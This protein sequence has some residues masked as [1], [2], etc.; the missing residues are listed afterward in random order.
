MP[1]TRYA[2]VLGLGFGDC[3][4]GLFVDALTRRWRAHSV[5][6][7]NGGA[8]AGH[9]VVT[10]PSGSLPSHHHTFSQFAAGTFNLGVRSILASPFW[11]HPGA[12]LVE[13]QRLAAI[14]QEDALSRLMIDGECPLVSPFHQAAG[15]LRELSRG[16]QAH[17]SCGV[18][19]GETVA[20]NQ[21]APGLS[22]HYRMLVLQTTAARTSLLDLLQTIR[23]ELLQ[24]CQALPFEGS[25]ASGN[26]QAANEWAV[27]NNEGLARQWINQ[28][29]QLHRACPASSA[30]E[31]SEQLRRPGAAI[32]EGAQGILLDECHGF[33]PHTTWSST[34]TA[35]AERV[36]KCYGLTSP[37]AHLGVLRS[38]LT[39]HGPGPLPTQCAELDA[40]SEPHNSSTGWQ[41]YFRRGHPD[42]VLQRYALDCVGPLHGLLLSHLDVFDRGMVLKWCEGYR[43]PHSEL[44]PRLASVGKAT[45]DEAL[46]QRLHPNHTQD[47]DHQSALT[48]LLNV[49]RPQYSVQP[50]RHADELIER[51]RSLSGLAVLARS[52]GPRAGDI[53]FEPGIDV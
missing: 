1:V 8:Q 33:H 31:I 23:K 41:G 42:A 29:T 34:G 38:Y 49:A 24:R 10:T 28:L 48:R 39:R 40:L 16:T 52:F 18:G 6:R 11:I 26:A 7:F 50:L 27:L 43:L 20:F 3:G 19:I 14:G 22:L 9:N 32:F 13:A 46:I 53:R 45:H 25:E 47:L 2:S 36:A 12:L 5:V 30:Q 4:K 21:S 17:G 51:M 15:R 35:A 44:D 37:I